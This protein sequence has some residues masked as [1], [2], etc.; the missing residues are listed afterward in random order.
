MTVALSSSETT[1]PRVPVCKRNPKSAQRY[2]PGRKEPCKAK[3]K[4][5]FSLVKG[6]WTVTSFVPSLK[7]PSTCNDI[8]QPLFFRS[9]MCMHPWT[10]LEKPFV[11]GSTWFEPCFTTSSPA[12]WTD[13]MLRDGSK[14]A[15]LQYKKCF[16]NT[17]TVSTRCGTAG[18]T[19]RLYI[20]T[21]NSSAIS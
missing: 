8:Y 20:H 14:S 12:F 19:C 21:P 1:D 11:T 2:T 15:I 3:A 10:L 6:L 13:P 16:V 17:C 5:P 7:V 18:S 9:Y 4:S